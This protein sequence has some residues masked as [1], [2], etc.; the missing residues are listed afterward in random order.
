[1]SLPTE[2]IND[3]KNM[4]CHKI[5]NGENK[6]NEI[7][8]VFGLNE[9]SQ[10][11]HNELIQ[12]VLQ[13][14]NSISDYSLKNHACNFNIISQIK[15]DDYEDD[16]DGKIKN[17]IIVAI[18]IDSGD[19]YGDANENDEL[20]LNYDITP[21]MVV[22]PN[23]IMN[24]FIKEPKYVSSICVNSVKEIIMKRWWSE[25]ISTEPNLFDIAG[26]GYMVH[27]MWCKTNV[28]EP[29]EWISMRERSFNFGWIGYNG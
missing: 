8:I 25:M 3:I 27:P 16:D 4:A 22:S 12:W 29:Y 17:T 14:L 9:S 24:C 11:V 19:Y 13:S 28:Q 2:I 7:L 20:L 6:S 21:Q 5:V 26:K 1:M 15:D 23:E 10:K 18:H